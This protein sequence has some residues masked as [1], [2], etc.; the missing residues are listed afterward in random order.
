MI[1]AIVPLPNFHAS[2]FLGGCIYGQMSRFFTSES[3]GFLPF[4]LDVS[5]G[6]NLP[7]IKKLYKY[8][9][10]IAENI[11]ELLKSSPALILHNPYGAAVNSEIIFI[12]ETPIDM[13]NLSFDQNGRIYPIYGK[14]GNGDTILFVPNINRLLTEQFCYT[15]ARDQVLSV[16]T[17]LDYLDSLAFHSSAFPPTGPRNFGPR[18]GV[19]SEFSRIGFSTPLSVL[20]DP[21][22]ETIYG[23]LVTK[24]AVFDQQV[25]REFYSFAKCTSFGQMI[26]YINSQTNNMNEVRS[27]A[28][29]ACLGWD[30]LGEKLSENGLLFTE[31][32][33]IKHPMQ[34]DAFSSVGRFISLLDKV[35]QEDF[36]F[37]IRADER[38]ISDMYMI[39]IDAEKCFERQSARLPSWYDL[40]TAACDAFEL[41]AQFGVKDLQVHKS[42]IEDISITDKHTGEL[43]LYVDL[44]WWT[45]ACAEGL[46]NSRITNSLTYGGC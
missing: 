5:I 12:S 11:D 23:E 37:D 4:D 9:I 19:I 20:L 16:A 30:E 32:P 35:G 33:D 21:K 13:V 7:F 26:P 6:R 10:Y 36:V 46:V 24:F 3:D 38:N 41:T 1:T 31:S 28:L 39:Q 22:D 29:G 42:C 25:S 14:Y 2:S 34:F 27:A 40:G 44:V 8:K 45:I 43:L 17:F 18:G 15:Q